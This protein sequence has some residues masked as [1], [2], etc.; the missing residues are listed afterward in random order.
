MVHILTVDDDEAIRD[1]VTSYLAAEGYRVSAAEDASA[2]FRILAAEPVDLVVLDLRLPDGDGLALVREIR[3]N[4]DIPVIIV[5]G[6]NAD[7]DRIIGLEVGA[8]DYLTKPFN[9][10][11]LLARIKAV[12]RRVGVG[13]CAPAK[14][15]P[16]NGTPVS[17]PLPDAV[18]AVVAFAGWTL[19][20]AAQRLRAPD[21]R[22]VDLTR[23]EFALL[24]A[25]VRRPQRVLS[26]EQLLDL[27]HGDNGEVFDRS[28]DV[29]I[30]RLRRKI[31]KNP[32]QPK[33]IRTERGAG[34]IFDSAV[35]TA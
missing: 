26:R 31:E 2:M 8:D 17:T 28:I 21:D 3:A 10:R 30:L 15:A 9:P 1:L 27:T 23:A 35:R 5:S 25:F 12:L 32:S 20:L 13:D 33:L 11:E 16:R 18:R 14:V 22:E 29:L 24:S 19:D 6:K 34:Y 7:I 4:D